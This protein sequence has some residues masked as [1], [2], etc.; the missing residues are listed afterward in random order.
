VIRNFVIRNFVPV[1]CTGTCPLVVQCTT[2][3]HADPVF[4]FGFRCGS[5]TSTLPL[6]AAADP[7]QALPSK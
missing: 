7:D 2:S 4:D 5:G 3:G 1:H 6:N